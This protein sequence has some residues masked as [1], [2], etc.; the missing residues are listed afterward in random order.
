MSDMPFPQEGHQEMWAVW[1]LH[2]RKDQADQGNLSSQEVVT[3]F[4]REG[5]GDVPHL[6]RSAALFHALF[7]GLA[8]FG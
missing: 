7:V 8:Q 6:S 2:A 4:M 5:T 1:L 3:E